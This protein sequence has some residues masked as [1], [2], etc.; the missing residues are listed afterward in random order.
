MSM[1]T[2]MATCVDV[3]LHLLLE[4]FAR[5]LLDEGVD[6]VVLD[7]VHDDREEQHDEDDLHG[8]VAF[9]PAQSPVAHLDDEGEQLDQEKHADLHAE[10]ADE[11]YDGLFEPPE[12][13]RRATIVTRFDGLRGVR[14]GRVLSDTV[15]DMEDED[16][17]RDSESRLQAVSWGV[18]QWRR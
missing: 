14:E 1:I 15:E 13:L 12:G 7:R 11:V 4:E 2:V 16:E 10:Q 9:G 8:G 17:D 18:S 5:R 6:D 3:I